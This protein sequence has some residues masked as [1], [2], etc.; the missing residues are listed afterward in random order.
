ML[1]QQVT[2]HVKVRIDLNRVAQNLRMPDGASA[3][4]GTARAFL[5]SAGFQAADDGTWVGPRSNLR[6][7]NHSEVVGVEPLGQ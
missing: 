6:R 5:L 4:P 2:E 3:G 7:L 1:Q